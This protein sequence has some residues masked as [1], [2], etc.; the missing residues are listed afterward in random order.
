MIELCN[1][2][3][4]MRRDLKAVENNDDEG[5]DVANV[6]FPSGNGKT[7]SGSSV[8]IH[9]NMAKKLDCRHLIVAKYENCTRTQKKNLTKNRFLRPRLYRNFEQVTTILLFNS[10]S[11]IARLCTITKAKCM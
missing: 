4:N 11:V 8:N 5:V 6:E 7:L 1:D 3:S 2:V 9:A 10:H